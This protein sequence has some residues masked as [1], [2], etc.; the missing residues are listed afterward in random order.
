MAHPRRLCLYSLRAFAF[1]I[2][3][4][5]IVTAAPRVLA[6][7]AGSVSEYAVKAAFVCKFAAY[8]EWPPAAFDKPDSPIVI[9]VL[10]NAA[11]ADEVARAAEG[12]V[13]EGRPL[14]VRRLAAGDPLQGLHVLYV[15]RSHAARSA[16]TMAAVRGKPVL[17]V[18]EVENGEASGIINFVID[19]S[20]VR[21]DVAPHL[22]DTSDLRVSARMLGVA[23]RVLQKET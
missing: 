18:T 9:G 20:K 1:A 23:R 16:D 4:A 22:A 8:V 10:A 2:V 6:Q 5:C 14:A 15:A 3:F 12:Q 17:T 19:A 11:V 13:V 21:F 7:R